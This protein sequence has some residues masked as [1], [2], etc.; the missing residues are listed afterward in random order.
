[1]RAV[2]ILVAAMMLGLT[3]G[4]GWSALASAK[5]RP[6]V[7]PKPKFDT[8]EVSTPKPSEL[9]NQWAARATEEDSPQPASAVKEK[10]TA[11]SGRA[12]EVEKLEAN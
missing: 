12:A 7:V 5:A 1:M 11:D 3:A 6:A 8:A 4:Y 10:E 2:A 9:D